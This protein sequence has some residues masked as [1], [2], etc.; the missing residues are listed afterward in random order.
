MSALPFDLPPTPAAMPRHLR[1]AVVARPQPRERRNPAPVPPAVARDRQRWADCSR[2]AHVWTD[3]PGGRVCLH[4]P[5]P[6]DQAERV[7]A[8]HRARVGG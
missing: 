7:R 5:I 8:A 6:E 1:V 2:G 4:C 3:V